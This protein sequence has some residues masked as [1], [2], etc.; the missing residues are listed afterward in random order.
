MRKF[1]LLD[2]KEWLEVPC[3]QLQHDKSIMLI[4]KSRFELDLANQTQVD[5]FF[6][7]EKPDEVII[8]AAKVG[9]IHN[10]A[11]PAEFAYQNLQIQNS[12]IHSAH[13][14]NVKSFCF[15]L[16]LCLS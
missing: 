8:A 5:K 9:G 11:Y 14:N 13:I 3:R 15:G 1:L 2:I 6:K 7:Q 10:N 12:I 4:C 16:F